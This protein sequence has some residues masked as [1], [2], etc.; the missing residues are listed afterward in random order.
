MCSSTSKFFWFLSPRKILI[1]NVVSFFFFCLLEQLWIRLYLL[2][3]QELRFILEGFKSEV[4]EAERMAL[5]KTTKKKNVENT[6]KKTWKILEGF[7][8]EV[9]EAVKSNRSHG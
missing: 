1:E 5:S 6:R 9:D 8:S 4:D 3:F 2:F 7:K